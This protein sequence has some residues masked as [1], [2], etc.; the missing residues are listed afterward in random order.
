MGLYPGEN[1]YRTPID[2]T[3]LLKGKLKAA[4]QLSTFLGFSLIS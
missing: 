1:K 4:H 3:G 2:H